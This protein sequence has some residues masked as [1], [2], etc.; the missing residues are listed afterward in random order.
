MPKLRAAHARC[1]SLLALRW[2]LLWFPAAAL[3]VHRRA[4]EASLDAY[5][6]GDVTESDGFRQWRGIVR[7]G[8]GRCFYRGVSRRIVIGDCVDSVDCGRAVCISA[9]YG[10]GRVKG[11]VGTGVVRLQFFINQSIT[12]KVHGEPAEAT[13]DHLASELQ[14]SAPMC[15]ACARAA[16]ER[17]RRCPAARRR[18]QLMFVHVARRRRSRITYP[19]SAT[20]F[21]PHEL[22]V[23]HSPCSNMTLF[24]ASD[25]W[26][27]S[28]LPASCQGGRGGAGGA[29]ACDEQRHQWQQS[30]CCPMINNLRKR[31]ARPLY[32]QGA[33]QPHGG[34]QAGG[35]DAPVARP[36]HTRSARPPPH[37]LRIHVSA[38][39]AL[40]PSRNSTTRAPRATSLGQRGARVSA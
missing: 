2:R 35:R 40:S 14:L 18:C 25:G 34:V 11:K 27:S 39:A 12:F 1:L 15:R 37:T 31:R 22:G 16:L 26:S 38:S 19:I 13:H 23:P 17:S 29:P 8:Q 21:S 32:E 33:G 5:R 24:S 10:P 7:A 30:R 9:R 6:L 20:S 28:L 4:R 3:G 36:L